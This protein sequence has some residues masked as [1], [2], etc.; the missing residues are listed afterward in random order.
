MDDEFENMPPSNSIS[1]TEP[2]NLGAQPSFVSSMPSPVDACP[3]VSMEVDSSINPSTGAIQKRRNLSGDS[4]V[5]TLSPAAKRSATGNTDVLPPVNNSTLLRQ[6]PEDALAEIFHD[7]ADCPSKNNDT[8]HRKS[9][10]H[11]YPLPP[12]YRKE[13]LLLSASTN[14]APKFESNS[15]ASS[16]HTLL[17]GKPP[18]HKVKT[19]PMKTKKADP[20]FSATNL[21]K[22]CPPKTVTKK[23]DPRLCGAGHSIP[24]IVT[25]QSNRSNYATK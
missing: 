10:I 18:P 14:N 19:V 6:S 20:R 13:D 4:S 24:S 3:Q 17:G 8:S 9:L 2:P 15:S 21:K 7:T 23:V 25:V 16:S 5:P 22:T 11:S 12:G 1:V